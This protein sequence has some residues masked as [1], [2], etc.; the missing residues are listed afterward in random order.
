MPGSLDHILKSGTVKY[1]QEL[2][3]IP[4][5]HTWEGRG[6]GGKGIKGGKE[7]K[8]KGGQIWCRCWERETGRS[9]DLTGQLA[10][11]AWQERRWWLESYS[12][13]CS[14]AYML[15]H[16]CVLIHTKSLSLVF[17]F[18]FQIRC[19]QRDGKSRG[20]ICVSGQC[21]AE[22]RSSWP[23]CIWSLLPFVHKP[24]LQPSAFKAAATRNTKSATGTAVPK[25]TS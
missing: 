15:K 19:R 21:S 23:C 18:P 6:R 1:L 7:R 17:P 24:P 3:S 10:Y 8:A 5:T 11:P 22:K 16:M 20:H 4:R 14:L 9:L 25:V 2:C 13:G 12:Q